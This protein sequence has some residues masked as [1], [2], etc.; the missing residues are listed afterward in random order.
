MEFLLAATSLTGETIVAIETI[1]AT[2]D[3][4]ALWRTFRTLAGKDQ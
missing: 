1:S 3:T 2:V 4:M